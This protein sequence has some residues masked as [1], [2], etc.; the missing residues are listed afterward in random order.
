VSENE[1]KSPDNARRTFLK[2]SGIALGG[3]VVGG[4]LGGTLLNN[5]PQ[6]V[7]VKPPES[8]LAP[9]PAATAK[10]P[11]KA[12]ENTVNFNEALMIFN[13]EQFENTQ[14]AVERIFPADDLGPGAKDLGVAFYIDHQL[15]SPWA[16]NVRDYMMGPFQKGTPSQGTQ[17]HL[18]RKDIFLLGVEAL[19]SYS[20]EKYKK[21]FADLSPAEQD[22]T[23]KVFEKGADVKLEPI[24][25]TTFF[26]LLRSYTLEGVYADPMY[27][28]NKDMKGW[29]MKRYPGN[30]PSYTADIEK[31]GFIVM[32]PKSLHDHMSH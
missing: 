9:T 13:Q 12:I 6:A 11:E 17:T 32:E 10:P 21:N 8:T 31:D 7:V 27:G 14:A 16:L 30:Q 3:V 20:Q 24:T 22:E 4:I 15:N 25:T 1:G 29:K 23:L 28:G 19:Q 26:S 2:Q 5:K 18:T